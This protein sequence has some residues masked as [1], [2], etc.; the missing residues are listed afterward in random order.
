MNTRKIS[1]WLV[2]IAAA[3]ALAACAATP[4]QQGTGE[5]FDDTVLTTKVKSVLLNDPSVSGLAVNVETFKG[6][7]QL[8]GFVKTA[9]E[10]AK[11]V[12]LARAVSGVKEVKNDILLR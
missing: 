2:T 6:V 5:Y 10:R 9:A 3:L 1:Q 8:S 7:V 4:K 12:E 11:A